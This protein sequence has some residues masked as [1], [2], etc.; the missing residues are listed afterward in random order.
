MDVKHKC[1]MNIE[2]NHHRGNDEESF[3]NTTWKNWTLV[4]VCFAIGLILFISL[5]AFFL[6]LILFF[7]AT[8]SGS[9]LLG[10][11]AKFTSKGNI[12]SKNVL[13]HEEVCDKN[14][15]DAKAK[16]I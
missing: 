14:S 5:V 2:D 13:V 1:E 11:P 7:S 8:E 16:K 9:P 6:S 10:H 15:R 3:K 12:V 4:E